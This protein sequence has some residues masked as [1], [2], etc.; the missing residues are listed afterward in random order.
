MLGEALSAVCETIR[1]SEAGSPHPPSPRRFRGPTGNA[2][3]HEISSARQSRSGTAV[4]ACQGLPSEFSAYLLG[5]LADQSP[6]VLA[7]AAGGTSGRALPEHGPCLVGGTVTL[8][9]VSFIT[10]IEIHSGEDAIAPCRYAAHL[11]TGSPQT[12]IRVVHRMLL[13][14]AASSA[15]ERPSS[16]RSCSGV[17]ESTPLRNATRI[18]LSVQFF[19]ENEP[20]CSLAVRE[21]VVHPPV[22]QHAV[23]LGRVSW[24]RLNTRLYRAL[25]PRPLDNRVFG[26]LTLSHHAMPGVAAYAVD[27]AATNG[28]FRPLYDGTTGVALSGVPQLLAVNLVRSNGS[29]IL[30]GHYRVDILPQPGILLGQKHFVSSRRQVLPLTGVADLGPGDLVGVADVP[31]LLVPLRALQHITHAT[32]PHPG[33]T[34]DS[35]VSAVVRSPDTEVAAPAVPSPPPAQLERLNSSQRSSF[36]YVWARHPPHLQEIAFDLHDPGWDPPAIEKLGDVLCGFPGVFSTSK[37][38]FGT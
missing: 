8:D 24:M 30:T 37:T 38:D 9:D 16:P 22:M 18:R 12:F 26:E 25:P 1:D 34:S 2:G 21:C 7:I 20:T 29:P 28:A 36:P 19:R 6:E 27:L 10:E 13:V 31:L 33:Q 17:G 14:G 32:R 35:Q 4:G 11:D 23:L 15:C 3:I 5:A